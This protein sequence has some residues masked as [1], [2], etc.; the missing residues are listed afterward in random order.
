MPASASASA[1]SPPRPNTNGSPP[2]S[3]TTSL[4]RG[5]RSISSSLI[6][7][8]LVDVAARLACR[9]RPARRRSLPH[10]AGSG[11]SRSWT[12]TSARAISSSAR[13]VARPGSPGPAPTRIDRSR[14]VPASCPEITLA[15]S[16]RRRSSPAPARAC[17]RR[18]RRPS[19][20]ASPAPS[21]A[22]PDPFAAV[23][24]PDVGVGAATPRPRARVHPDRR[25]GSSFE[26]LHDRALGLQPPDR[27]RVVTRSRLR[28]AT[29][30]SSSRASSARIPWPGA[31][32]NLL[33]R[34]HAVASRFTPEPAKAGERQ[35]DRVASPSASFRRRVS[36]LPR[37]SVTLEVGP[38]R[39]ELRAPPQAGRPHA[40]AAR[41]ARRASA[42]PPD[43]RVARILR[44][45]ARRRSQ[46]RPAARRER[47]LRCGRRGRLS[48]RRSASSISLTKRDLSLGALGSRPRPFAVLIGTSSTSASR[49]RLPRSRARRSA[50]APAPE[51]CSACR[52]GSAPRPSRAGVSD[53]SSA[54]FAAKRRD[55]ERAPAARR[56]SARASARMRTSARPRARRAPAA[57]GCTRRWRARRCCAF[58][59]RIGCWSRRL[60]IVAASSSTRSRSASVSDSQR[61]SFSASTWRTTARPAPA[62]P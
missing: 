28:S 47:P 24:Q 13:L 51:R 4:P 30:A 56:L 53:G 46:A 49:R 19:A 23:G 18:A 44:R 58:R 45:G 38:D 5:A 9:R 16:A 6:S 1:S 34:G 25:V 20:A 42:A 48:S 39:E 57:P 2:L 59:C 40:R 31:G 21:D 26:R 55:P 50:P 29:A 22:V 43:E 3:R 52:S 60:A 37:S 12:I 36:T 14:R 54:L 11:T 15:S 61:P 7:S 41:E 17:A 10:R 62:A 33:A 27:G 32:T 35:H 8:W